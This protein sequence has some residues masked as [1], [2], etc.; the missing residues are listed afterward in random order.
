MMIYYVNKLL[1]II[2]LMSCIVIIY[3]NCM[4]YVALLFMSL[5]ELLMIMNLV[6]T[7]LHIPYVRVHV[8]VGVCL[9][10]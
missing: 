4:H 5:Q 6:E 1:F 7:F 2:E 3:T 10:M 9:C 8:Y